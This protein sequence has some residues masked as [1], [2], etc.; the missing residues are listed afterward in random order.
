M[1]TGLEPQAFFEGGLERTKSEANEQR[2][3]KSEQKVQEWLSSKPF[4]GQKSDTFGRRWSKSFFRN[5][6][7]T[8]GGE[9]ISEKNWKK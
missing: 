6:L 9:H 4:G 2:S 8:D 5:V 1:C 7:P 3:D